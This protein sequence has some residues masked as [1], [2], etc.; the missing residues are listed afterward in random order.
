M[1]FCAVNY[2]QGELNRDFAEGNEAILGKRDLACARARA[3]VRICLLTNACQIIILAGVRPATKLTGFSLPISRKR[4]TADNAGKR[5]K[6][7]A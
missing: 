7:K 6:R 4:R 5:A 2:R 1:H 3:R